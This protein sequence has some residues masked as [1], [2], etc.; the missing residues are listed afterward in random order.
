MDAAGFLNGGLFLRPGD[1][2]FEMAGIVASL[3]KPNDPNKATWLIEL[4]RSISILLFC[5]RMNNI[6]QNL[7]FLNRAKFPPIAAPLGRLRPVG[8]NF[9][10]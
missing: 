8:G 10:L 2:R 5:P 9:H 3:R 7:I 4:G 1:F 6:L